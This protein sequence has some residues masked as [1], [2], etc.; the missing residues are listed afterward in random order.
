M[1]IKSKYLMFALAIF[2]VAIT[3][4]S[5]NDNPPY[6]EHLTVLDASNY[7]LKYPDS[8]A[9]KI[10]YS[11][12]NVICSPDSFKIPND[13]KLYNFV[14]DS[15]LAKDASN[16]AYKFVNQ[17][18]LLSD[19]LI[20]ITQL[21]G[22]LRFNNTSKKLIVGH[23]FKIYYSLVTLNGKKTYL[24]YPLKFTLIP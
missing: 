9:R 24:K 2:S 10:A 20:T 13:Y 22:I 14:I 5:C 4:H 12:G 6:V 18:K 23:Q 7:Y 11:K 17:G 1:K 19:T 3:F 21:T 16:K 15:I 8:V